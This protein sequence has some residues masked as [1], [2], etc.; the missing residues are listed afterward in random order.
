LHEL[1][2]PSAY[3][4]FEALFFTLPFGKAFEKEC[5]LSQ[6]SRPQGLATL[7]TVL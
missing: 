6:K 2:C 1:F 5:P 7:S 4:V 3:P